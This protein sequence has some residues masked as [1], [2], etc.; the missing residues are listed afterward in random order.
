MSKADQTA[1]HVGSSYHPVCHYDS[2]ED[3]L[4]DARLSTDEKRVILSSWASNM[5]V[6]ES[7]PALRDVPGIPHPI[8][9]D[10]ILTALKQLD[11]DSDPPPRGGVAMRLPR[12]SRLDCAASN[13]SKYL[14]RKL[15]T[16]RRTLPRL[17]LSSGAR[18]T[19]EANVR[20]YRKLLKTQLT[21]IERSFVERRLAEE[22]RN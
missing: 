2:P 1:H 14:T 18:W 15:A 5:Y 9:L 8:R 19:R 11:E 4:D 12:F 21:D 3:V 16:A 17:D 6:V 22:L 13:E 7:Q 10:Y 20:R